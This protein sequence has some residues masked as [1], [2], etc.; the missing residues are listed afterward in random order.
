MQFDKKKTILLVEDEFLLA[1]NEKSQL[2]KYG[3][4]VIAVNSGENAVEA[5]NGDSSIDLIL[6]DINLGSGIDGTKAAEQILKDHDIPIVFLS[7]H[8]EPDVVEKTEKIT[9]YGYVVKNS[10]ITVLDASIKMAF[11]LSD[12]NKKT[13]KLN[14]K[15]EATLDAIPDLMF[16]IGIDGTY[17]DVHAPHPD[18]LVTPSAEMLIGKRIHDFL[19]A[20][21]AAIVMSAI[22]EANEKGLSAGRQYELAVEGGLRWFEI[23]VS[24][25]SDLSPDP[26]FIYICRDITEGKRMEEALEKR[27][28]LLTSPLDASDAIAFTDLFSIREIQKIQDDFSTATGVASII[29]QV[30][31]T[32]ITSPSNFCRLCSE[33]VRKSEM[34]NAN[35]MKSDAVLGKL[36]STAPLIQNCLSGGLWDAG[37]SITVG[38][39]HIANWLIG[40]VR[41]E[42][43]T[44]EGMVEY[45]RKIGVDEQEFIEAF[46]EVPVMTREKFGQIA[47]TLFGLAYQLSTLAYQNVQQA[48]LLAERK[49]MEEELR[50]SEGKYRNLFN[51]AEVGMLRSRLDGSEVL[52]CNGKILSILGKTRDEVIGKPA[53][54]LWADSNER[55]E[56]VKVLHARGHVDELECHLLRK[57]GKIITCITSLKLYPETGILE[58]SIIDITERKE[59]E[60]SLQQKER[61]LQAVF[62]AMT[63]GFSIQEVITDE[64]GKP[65]DLRFVDANPAFEAQT[66]LKNE[67]TFGHT[68][69]ELFPTAEQYWIERYGK[70]GLTG[71]PISFEA[72]FSPLGKYYHVSAFQTEPKQFGVLFMDIAEARAAREETRKNNE[73]LRESDSRL[74]SLVVDMSVGVLIQ[75]PDA[76]ILMSNPQA[77]ELLG[78]SE[79]QLLGKTSFDPDW[80]VVH[81]DGSSFPGANHPVPQAIASLAPVRDVVMGV[82]RPTTENRVWLKV[83]AIP[84]IEEGKLQHVVCTFIDIS[85]RIQAEGSLRDS[86]AMH[87]RMI[88]NTSDVI[89]I[90]GADRIMKYKSPNIER[91]FGWRPEEVIGTDGFLNVHPDDLDRIRREF[92]GLIQENNASTTIECRYRCKDG[93]YKPIELTAKNLLDDSVV[94]GVLL[95]YHDIT[96][97]RKA[98]A[99]LLEMQTI[100]KAAI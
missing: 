40:Q 26:R 35:C 27:I 88:S 8:I 24:R 22:A 66:G 59:L 84:H 94:G 70:V 16:E 46:R 87:A 1:M 18:L 72:Q 41:D 83:D 67:E 91:W 49:K 32:P 79:D 20:E 28:L 63:E 56:M 48:R 98:E 81:E 57:D 73:M 44:E 61:R 10:S 100:L 54:V 45:A 30:D 2:I 93:T 7:S 12:A 97:R 99:E 25:M 64:F 95:N 6:M 86:E 53:S 68:L 52:E 96:H 92:S 11:K 42:T 60:N 85:K 51:K 82:Y 69:R 19:P 75:G 15:Y 55:V 34:G 58:G 3:Y 71:E 37:T 50:F 5:M 23:S 14:S 38:G 89:G 36:N 33:I 65:V 17:H 9:S 21:T 31:G 77:L 29:T 13:M 47:S 78:L 43:Q 4:N 74:K 76:E 62:N 90:I 80:N 39:K